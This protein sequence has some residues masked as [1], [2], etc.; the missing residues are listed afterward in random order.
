MVAFLQWEIR[1]VGQKR[2]NGDVMGQLME[3]R[4]GKHQAGLAVFPWKMKV[5]YKLSLNQSND[6]YVSVSIFA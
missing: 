4:Q 2:K 1:Y 3:N 5:Y 6:F